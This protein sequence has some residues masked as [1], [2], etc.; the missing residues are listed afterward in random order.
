MLS[1]QEINFCDI[2]PMKIQAY[3][4][5]WHSLAIPTIKALHVD[6]TIMEETMMI[7]RTSNILRFVKITPYFKSKHWNYYL[8][9]F[10]RFVNLV[11]VHLY[12]EH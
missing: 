8:F 2:K 10:A 5:L 9:F 4:L 7:E 11:N 12:S 1:G 6:M 3:L